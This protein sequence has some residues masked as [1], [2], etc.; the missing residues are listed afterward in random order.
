M[1]ESSHRDMQYNDEMPNNNNPEFDNNL[2]GLEDM[3]EHQL[4][5]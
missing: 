4:T 2:Q 5:C 1:Q 3:M